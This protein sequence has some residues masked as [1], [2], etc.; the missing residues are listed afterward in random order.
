[1]KQ[2][3][4][5][6]LGFCLICIPIVRAQSTELQFNANH[7]FKI[8]Q[9]TDVHYIHNDPRSNISVERINEVLD[10][11]R[12]DL[13]VFTGDI[14]FGKPAEEGLRT[15]LQLVSDRQIPFT[16]T[17][18]N[19]DDEQGLSREKLFNIIKTIPYNLM[20]HTEGTSGMGNHLLTIKSSQG[21]STAFILYCF[22]SHSY[23]SIE[24]IGGYD[25][26]KSNQIAW[27]QTQSSL[28]TKTNK[29]VPIPSLAFFHIPLPEY[30]Q[31]ANNESA[32]L[33]GIRKEKACAPELNSGLFAA[34]KQQNDVLGVFTG[35]DHDND[36][37]VY[38][39][40]ILLG[41]GRYTGGNTVY[42]HLTNGAR[43]IEIDENTRS[44]D[45]WIRIKG[46]TI[47]HV[48]YPDDFIKE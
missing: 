30:N 17:F 11:E 24:G 8:V 13:V 18:G 5:L 38:W 22:D 32:I 15:I 14:I 10:S 43:V 29:G 9:F 19:H 39:K 25:F 42:N 20:N 36:Y 46:E 28:F 7:K 16:V 41:Y 6:L 27:Y 23:S 21:D 31:A 34:M 47:S 3:I 26:I 12:P 35:H 1:M 40:G 37:V 4:L 48:K 2:Q 44:F 45:T 33:Y